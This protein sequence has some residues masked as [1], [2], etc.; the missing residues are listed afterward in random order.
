MDLTGSAL[1][2]VPIISQLAQQVSVYQEGHCSMELTS[3][4]FETDRP[5]LE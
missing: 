2:P 4:S 5:V 3:D 1:G